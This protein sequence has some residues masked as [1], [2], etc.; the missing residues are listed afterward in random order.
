M[1]DPARDY[2]MLVLGL[3]GT[4]LGSDKRL[5]KAALPLVRAA[6]EKGKY[7]VLSSGRVM[8][9][10]MDYCGND[11][12]GCLPYAILSMGTELYDF[13]RGEVVRRHL[14]P[15]TMVR[16]VLEV[17]AGRDVIMHAVKMSVFNGSASDLAPERLKRFSL[18]HK[19]G[20][21]EHIVSR[22]D[23]LRQ[24]LSSNIDQIERIVIYHTSFEE[25]TDTYNRLRDC[26]LSLAYYHATGLH[27]SP[28]G[29]SKSS[30][31]CGLAW[32]LG[33]SM[34]DVMALGYSVNDEQ[35]CKIAGCSIAMGG[36]VRSVKDWCDLVVADNDHDGAAE[37]IERYF[38]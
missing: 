19:S 26:P 11:E 36:A 20:V 38:L 34:D 23:D 13:E 28:F 24:F 21:F 10:I 8:W 33:I 31:L 9:E 22:D 7:V 6:L 16:K 32:Q 29:V 18:D 27:I 1:Y 15:S 17:T 3:D 12:L 30:G 2:R 14:L 35:I 37:A 25:C 4:L 5:R